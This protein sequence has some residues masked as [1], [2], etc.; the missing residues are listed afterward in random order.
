MTGAGGKF[1]QPIKASKRLPNLVKKSILR[2]VFQRKG[3]E[4][5]KKKIFSDITPTFLWIMWTRM[6]PMPPQHD[7]MRLDVPHLWITQKPWSHAMLDW[8]EVDYLLVSVSQYSNHTTCMAE[9]GCG[10]SS[11]EEIESDRQF[12]ASRFSQ[13]LAAMVCLRHGNNYRLIFHISILGSCRLSNWRFFSSQNQKCRNN[14]DKIK[15]FITLGQV[16]MLTF[17]IEQGIFWKNFEATSVAA[18]CF[19]DVL[20]IRESCNNK[21]HVVNFLSPWILNFF[22]LMKDTNGYAVAVFA[23]YCSI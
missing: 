7:H 12:E 11:L 2:S 9:A 4:Q 21:S 23:G 6:I 5:K 16:W 8:F 1:S 17:S 15:S 10:V 13:V 18:Q 22:F 3:S 19:S 20:G 14:L